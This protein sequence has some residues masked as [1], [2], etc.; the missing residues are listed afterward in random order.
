MLKDITL[1]LEEQE[2]KKISYMID[3]QKVFL[4]CLYIKIEKAQ[5]KE[6]IIELLYILRYYNLI[7]ITSKK[8]IK[9]MQELKEER[10]TLEDTLIRKANEFKVI[11]RI[12]NEESTNMEIIRNVLYTKIIMLDNIGIE[13]QKNGEALE[14]KF[15]DGDIYEKTIVIP[16]Y[17]KKQISVKFGKK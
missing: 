6:E 13:L 15:Y 9:D 10:I 1:E 16:V 2:K 12:T 8:Q 11:N 17:D 14:I 4:K 7:F 3:L 5:E